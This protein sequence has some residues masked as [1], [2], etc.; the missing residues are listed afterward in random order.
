MPIHL[1]G[2]ADQVPWQ[3][4]EEDG[5][6]GNIQSKSICFTKKAQT[7]FLMND[8]IGALDVSAS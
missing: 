8:G 7:G 5:N 4:L 3:A 6:E 2:R 1:P